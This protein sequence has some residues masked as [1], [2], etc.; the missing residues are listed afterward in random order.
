[1]LTEKDPVEGEMDAAGE[2]G[3]IAEVMSLSARF[4]V[5]RWAMG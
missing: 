3:R 4:Q 5:E 1:M 2:R